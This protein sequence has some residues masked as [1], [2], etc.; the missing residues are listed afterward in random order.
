M[1]TAFEKRGFMEKSKNFQAVY[2][3]TTENITGYITQMDIKNK[4]ILTLG[5]SCDQAFNSL[6]LGANEVTIFDINE[7]IEEYYELKRKLILQIP[8]EKLVETVIKSRKVPFLEEETFSLKQLEQMNLYL[9]NDDNYKKL[10][11]IL[12]KRTVHFITGNIFDI[13]S[14]SIENKQYDRMILS[15]VLQYISLQNVPI[16]EAIYK[17]YQD[18]QNHLNPEGLIQLYYLYGSIY[19]K[20][21]TKII[22]EFSKHD[23][24]LQH[25]MW[26][27]KD[28]AI[29]VKKK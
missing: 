2:P 13:A 25:V 23:V 1:I 28:S 8:R 22:N 11:E 4:D 21:F 19:P 26:D 24:L 9:Q 10:R 15:N 6:L 7:R 14:S 20:H 18:L 29:L 27:E 12:E 16:E 5:S 3:F 17:I